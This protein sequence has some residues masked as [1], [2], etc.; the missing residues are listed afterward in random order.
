[1]I[2]DKP[3]SVFCEI[4]PKFSKLHTRAIK[5]SG[6]GEKTGK[7]CELNPPNGP[8]QER[9]PP[10]LTVLYHGTGIL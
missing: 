1:M 8:Q 4:L 2:N 3:G 6:G 7:L 5:A 10:E 9:G